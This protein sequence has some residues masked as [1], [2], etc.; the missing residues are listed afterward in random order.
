MELVIAELAKVASTFV[1][2]FF[3]FWAAIPAGLALGLAPL[4]VIAITT[5]SYASGVALVAL[6]GGRVRGGVRN[7]IVSRFNRGAMIQAGGGGGSDD[8]KAGGNYQRFRRIWER[9]GV[10]GLGLAAPMTLGAQI[11]AALGIALE[12]K[13]RRLFVAMTLGALAWSI[14]LTLGVRLG[15]LAVTGG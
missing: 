11:G 9:F 6:V 13:P 1:L 15:V 12:A 7:W 8:G 5:L 10:V 3:S 2:A 4:A 14:V